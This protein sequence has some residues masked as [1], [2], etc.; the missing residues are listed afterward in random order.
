MDWLILGVQP[1]SPSDLVSLLQSLSLHQT[2]N[3]GK[4][5][6]SNS[7]SS[8]N[9]PFF[10]AGARQRLQERP[11]LSVYIDK[12]LGLMLFFFSGN[13]GGKLE[14]M[15]VFQKLQKDLGMGVALESFQ[16]VLAAV[17]ADMY[18]DTVSCPDCRV[19]GTNSFPMTMFPFCL[20]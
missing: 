14:V 2:L 15:K 12:A 7:S 4:P 20:C 16:K 5:L 8:L 3:R 10:F 19:C 13:K 6:I 18:H 17:E 11:E 9:L 1:L